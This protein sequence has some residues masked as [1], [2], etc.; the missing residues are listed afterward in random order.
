MA[1]YIRKSFSSGPFR[2]NLSKSG[3][4]LSFGVKGA[5]VGAGPRGKYVHA[6]RHGLYYRKQ[7]SSGRRRSGGRTET[8]TTRPQRNESGCGTLVLVALGIVLAVAAFRWIVQHPG[9][10]TGAVALVAAAGAL[11]WGFRV[12]ANRAV[13]HYKDAL[14]QTFVQQDS[15]ATESAITVVSNAQDRLPKSAGFA[16]K[17]QRVEEDVYRAV[18]DKVL[19]DRLVSREEQ[20]TI[21]TL[22][23]TLQIPDADRLK[24]KKEIF[25]AAYLQAI[26]DDEV[27][28]DEL[29]N[30]SNLIAGLSISEKEVESELSVVKEVMR[31]QSLCLPLAP[32]PREELDIN[33]QKNE[34]AYYQSKGEVLSRKKSADAPDGYEYV[35][36]REGSLVVTDKRIL[37]VG[38]GTTAIRLSDIADIS[39]DIDLG[40]LEISKTSSS[41]PV[42]IRNF[43]PIFTGKVIDLLL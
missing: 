38:E 1:F 30:L 21:R 35:V 29:G 28:E 41:R 8:R 13:R 2:L 14:D 10:S 39:A 26:E 5:R 16:K 15:V 42:Y 36:K 4:G 7:L 25:S 31:A 37:V 32:I 24:W 22:D 40:M 12:R 18:L 3:F 19:D 11:R 43:E 6:G 9:L 23:A 20:A 27:T 17:I 33:I 34:Q